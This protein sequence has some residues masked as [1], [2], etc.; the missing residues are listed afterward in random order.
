MSSIRVRQPSNDPDEWTVE[1]IGAGGEGLWCALQGGRIHRTFSTRL[2][3]QWFVRK[4]RKQ[5]RE[6]R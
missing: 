5:P 6:A 3:A 4:K 1:W 2:G